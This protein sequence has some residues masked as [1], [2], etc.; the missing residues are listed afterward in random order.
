MVPRSKR[1]F[2][3]MGITLEIE[4]LAAALIAED[5]AKDSRT[6]ATMATRTETQDA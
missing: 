6:G 5:A 3:V 1:Y 4:D 2:E